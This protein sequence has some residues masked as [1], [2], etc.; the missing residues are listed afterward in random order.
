MRSTES[1]KIVELQ[2]VTD[3]VA[4]AAA[5]QELILYARATAK[6]AEMIRDEAIRAA[7]G[8]TTITI[9]GLADRVRVKRNVIVQALRGTSKPADSHDT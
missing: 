6:A 5:A 8:S 7:R 9:D 3:P 1:P 4:R 2:A